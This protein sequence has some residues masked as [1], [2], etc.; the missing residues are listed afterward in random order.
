MSTPPD[1]EPTATLGRLAL[2]NA[3]PRPLGVVVRVS[4]SAA[5]P[6]IFRLA[7]TPCVIGSAAPSDILVSDPAVSRTHLSLRLVP[8]GVAVEDLG[9]RNG[10]WYLG[11]RVE[12]MT[13]APGSVLEVGRATLALDP[14][15][16]SLAEG[17]PY[18]GTEYS[19]MVGRSHAMRRVFRTLQRLEGSLV[20]V[21][22]QGE[23]GVGKELVA[24]ALHDRS[25]VSAGPFVAVNC[26]AF[27]RELIA[28]E[29]FGHVKGAFTG[30]LAARKGAFELAHGGTLFLDEIGELPL[31]VQPMLLRTLEAFEVRPV[32]A[33]AV[34]KVRVRVVAATNRDLVAETA[35]GRFRED[36]YYRLAVVKLAVP[37]LR[38][39]VEDLDVLAHRFAEDVGVALDEAVLA[40]LRAQ[41]FPGNARELRNVVY[42]F[43]AIGALPE[44]HSGFA[45]VGRPEGSPAA[46]EV[47]LEQLVDP[48][49]PYADQKEALVDRFT[50]IYL[51]SLMRHTAGNQSAAARLAGLDRTYLGRLLQ[52]FG[53]P[54]RAGV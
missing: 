10:T 23:S 17:L 31:D 6:K 48:Q 49:R 32:G 15:Q 14:D 27:A 34:R 46:L 7:D 30:A 44:G 52:K 18:E 19:G 26:G 11:Q 12:R 54:G 1:H 41:A 28:S 20:N 47:L 51:R 4:G 42:A 35:A 5:S 37:P 29:L 36:L 33:D 38:E 9:S 24:R 13:L 43:A 16:E 50:E 22:V 21:L 53:I 45:G 8:Q 3:R 40:R 39:R 25:S 2:P